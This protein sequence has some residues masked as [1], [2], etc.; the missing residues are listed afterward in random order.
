MFTQSCFIRKNTKSLR[1][2]LRDIGYLG[3][4]TTNFGKGLIATN[5]DNYYTYKNHQRFISKRSS[6]YLDRCI[7]CGENEDL[8]LAIASLRSDNKTPQWF[9]WYD[10][11]NDEYIWKKMYYNHNWE[12][13]GFEHHKASVEELIKHFL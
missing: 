3:N 10:K 9:V 2:K 13:W 11:E 8:F 7:D 4:T 5:G 1:A 6:I 12:Y